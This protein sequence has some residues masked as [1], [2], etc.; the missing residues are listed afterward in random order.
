M[1]SLQL[2]FLYYTLHKITYT[3]HTPSINI[4]ASFCYN[5]CFWSTWRVMFIRNCVPR[6][7]MFLNCMLFFMLLFLWENA[8]GGW[9]FDECVFSSVDICFCFSLVQRQAYS[10][11]YVVCF[12]SLP[13]FLSLLCL[14]FVTQTSDYI[15]HRYKA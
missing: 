1:P 11:Y 15:K 9:R 3:K 12:K 7:I 14:C 8:G 10:I 13:W 4:C 2:S 5:N 6:G